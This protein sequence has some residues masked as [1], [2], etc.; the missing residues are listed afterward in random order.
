MLILGGL[1]A[2]G[3]VGSVVSLAREGRRA[4]ARRA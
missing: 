4:A 2:A 1:A 3:A